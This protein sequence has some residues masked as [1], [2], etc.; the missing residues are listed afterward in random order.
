[1]FYSIWLN[2]SVGTEMIY[3]PDWFLNR[4]HVI[5]GIIQSNDG[6]F[7]LE[8]INSKIGFSP[9]FLNYVTV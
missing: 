9:N 2:K 7:S 3:F 6:V 8:E 5:G 1:M 4:I